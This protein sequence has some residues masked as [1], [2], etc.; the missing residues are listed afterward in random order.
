MNR[1]NAPSPRS[2]YPTRTTCAT[3]PNHSLVVK[4][5]KEAV[6]ARCLCKVEILPPPSSERIRT[7]PGSGYLRNSNEHYSITA[8]GPFACFTPR[9][10][11]A[12]A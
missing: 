7:S 11:Q 1:V 2:A 12:H 8:T 3:L 9:R 6:A 10:R 5:K 4:P